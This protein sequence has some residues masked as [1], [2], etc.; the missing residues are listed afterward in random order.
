MG[1]QSPGVV[2]RVFRFLGPVGLFG[3]AFAVRA[4]PRQRVFAGDDVLFFGND[5]F[6]HLRRIVY[7]VVRFPDLLD[8]DLYINYPHG[9]KP[10]W[11]PLF[12]WAVALVSL[13]FYRPGELG[14]R[15]PWWRSGGW[16][17]ATWTRPA[18]SS[19]P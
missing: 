8:F 11:P 6:Y 2:P 18:P 12:D 19:P 9:A 10:I 1:T 13:P 17:G 3:L 14:E 15:R 16:P 4:L 7:S 5:A